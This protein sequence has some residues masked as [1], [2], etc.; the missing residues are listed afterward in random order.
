MYNS[1]NSNNSLIPAVNWIPYTAYTSG[2]KTRAGTGALNN[3]FSR[4]KNWGGRAAPNLKSYLSN[5]NMNSGAFAPEGFDWTKGSGLKMFGKNV[6]KGAN[7]VSGVVQGAQA[8]KGI[9]DY[10]KARQSN[11]DM[12]D[13]IIVS[14]T[15]NPLLSSY[16]T[17]D[18]MRLVNA[19]RKGN[20]DTSSDV[21]DFFKGIGS[22]L[23]NAALSTLSGF[24]TGGVPGAIIGGVGSLAN[25]GIS[26]LSAGTE[27]ESAELAALY[28]ALMDAEAQ[29]RSMKRPNFTGLGI[30]QQYQNMYA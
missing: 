29:Y 11:E 15:S 12:L 1:N 23:G 14:A 7:V 30:Q 20:Y 6:G 26:G 8:L 16:L 2:A 22:G 21:G 3:L 5:F 9:S 17:S 24:V 4:F 18:Q 25:S 10:S 19:I 13:D 27:E 28:Q